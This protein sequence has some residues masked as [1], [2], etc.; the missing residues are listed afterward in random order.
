[1]FQELKSAEEEMEYLN[2]CIPK[3]EQC[4]TKWAYKIFGEWQSSRRNKN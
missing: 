3:S 2:S 1:M 4:G